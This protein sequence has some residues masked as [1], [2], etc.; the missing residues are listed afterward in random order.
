MIFKTKKRQTYALHKIIDEKTSCEAFRLV[1]GTGRNT[2]T[3]HNLTFI[4]NF[5]MR[6]KESGHAV[7]CD[8]SFCSKDDD[9]KCGACVFDTGTGC[10]IERK[11]GDDNDGI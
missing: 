6:L 8:E 5:I 10:L 3:T 1:D 11:E 2:L 4:L 9:G 7:I